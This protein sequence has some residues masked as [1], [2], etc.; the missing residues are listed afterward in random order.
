MGYPA[1]LKRLLL[2][3]SRPYN[4]RAMSDVLVSDVLIIER[5]ESMLKQG[6]LCLR[7]PMT[8]QTLSSFQNA[9]RNEFAPILILDLAEV[10]YIDSAGLGSLVSAYITSHKAGR[11]VVLAGVN[12]RILRLFEITRVESLFLMFSTLDDAI[13]A[14]IA[15]AHA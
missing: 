3:V 6:V 15:P 12:S 13:G 11:Q 5:L 1:A 8:A 10:P 7:G 14:F 2:S 9:I 4:L